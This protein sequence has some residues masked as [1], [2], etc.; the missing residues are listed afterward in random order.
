M[1]DTKRLR[2]RPLCDDDLGLLHQIFSDPQ[3]M[4]Y[5]DR[6]AWDD[7][8]RTR[9][10]LAALM[11]DAPDEHL[12]YAVELD[13]IC[14]GR[15]GMWKRWEIGYIFAPDHWGHGYATESVAALIDD[16]W[17]RFPQAD[18]LTAEID[19]RNTGSA[20]LLNKLGFTLTGTA[21]RNFLYGETEWVDTAY[22]ELERPR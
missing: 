17:R 11:Q 22:F 13:G 14:I 1:I 5:W 9:A 12:E 6:P 2:L 7:I 16:I 21:E 10:L 18:R 19:P 3:A 20:R 4:R 8:D 15:V